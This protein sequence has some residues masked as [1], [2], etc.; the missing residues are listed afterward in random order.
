MGNALCW[1]R[2]P[3]INSAPSPLLQDLRRKAARLVA[4]KCTLAARVDSFHES[5]EGKVRH[6]QVSVCVGLSP[7][8]DL[9]AF[10]SSLLPWQTCSMKVGMFSVLGI[11]VQTP[12]LAQRSGLRV[13]LSLSPFLFSCLLTTS[14]GAGGTA[15]SYSDQSPASVA[16]MFWLGAV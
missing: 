9:S 10:S 11:G 2:K 16:F 15:V 3:P 6:G 7:L 12:S 1:R 5:T 13:S 8:P 4:A 14:R